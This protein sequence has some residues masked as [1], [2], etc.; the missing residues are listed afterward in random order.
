MTGKDKTSLLFSVKHESG[1]LFKALQAFAKKNINMTKIESRPSKRKAWEYVFY[2]DIDGH[3]NDK[4]IVDA[5]EEFSKDV[6]FLKILGSY[7]KGE[8]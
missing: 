2:V 1:S 8:K 6:A 3:I 7:P 5:V 4:N